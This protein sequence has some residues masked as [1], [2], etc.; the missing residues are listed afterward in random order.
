MGNQYRACWWAIKQAR[1]RAFLFFF[2]LGLFIYFRK[3]IFSG[4]LNSDLFSDAESKR[5]RS[6]KDAAAKL[7]DHECSSRT[8]IEPDRAELSP[9]SRLRTEL[10]GSYQRRSAHFIPDA[11]AR[12]RPGGQPVVFSS[13]FSSRFYF[14]P[15][16]LS[17]TIAELVAS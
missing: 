17:E 15:R 9:N 14:S 2:F 7:L 12:T 5:G 4:H 1:Q 8:Y 3:L 11:G 10:A 13:S 6:S 16:F